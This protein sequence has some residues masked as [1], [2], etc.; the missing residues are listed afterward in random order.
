MVVADDDEQG[1]LVV[2]E[3][4]EQECIVKRVL[5]RINDKGV[6]GIPRDRSWGAT[7]LR[8]LPYIHFSKSYDQA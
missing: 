3:D 6:V 1:L 7:L 8:E 2:A 4:D 5:L